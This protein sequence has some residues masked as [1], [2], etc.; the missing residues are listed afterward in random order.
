MRAAN[1]PPSCTSG[2]QGISDPLRSKTR[3]IQ[4]KTPA[5][6][7][8]SDGDGPGPTTELNNVTAIRIYCFGYDILTTLWLTSCGS[9]RRLFRACEPAVEISYCHTPSYRSVSVLFIVQVVPVVLLGMYIRLFVN[10]CF[11]S[12]DSVTRL[13]K[14]LE[15]LLVEVGE[16]WGDGKV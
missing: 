6:C 4:P 2:F 13:C 16:L 9:K 11:A 1:P 10:A 3:Y 15:D 14:R 7:L 8:H 12:R 5:K